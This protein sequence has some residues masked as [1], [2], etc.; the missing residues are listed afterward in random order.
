VVYINIPALV[1]LENIELNEEQLELVAGGG[2]KDL[3]ALVL[4]PWL[5]PAIMIKNAI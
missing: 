4:M 3:A 2:I 1:N 5:V